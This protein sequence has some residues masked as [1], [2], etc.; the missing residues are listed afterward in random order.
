MSSYAEIALKVVRSIQVDIS[1]NPRDAWEEFSIKAFPDSK[2]SQE[3]S[4]P[5]SSFLGLC[6]EDMV[7]YVPKGKYT[8]SKDNKQYAI[9]AIGLLKS[10]PTLNEKQLWSMIAGD[11]EPNYQM[12]VVMAL[13]DNKYIK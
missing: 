13:F 1:I 9:V 12:S 8:R 5:K 6:E 2:S 7:R 3:K 4:C 10:N 11:K